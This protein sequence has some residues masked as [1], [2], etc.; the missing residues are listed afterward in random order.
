M[1]RDEAI[2]KIATITGH[3][4]VTIQ[5][6]YPGSTENVPVPAESNILIN[7]EQMGVCGGS[8]FVQVSKNKLI[9]KVR[10][11]PA[12]KIAPARFSVQGDVINIA[13][14]SSHWWEVKARGPMCIGVRLLQ[15]SADP[16]TTPTAPRDL[17]AEISAEHFAENHAAVYA[18][19][20]NAWLVDP[21]DGAVKRRLCCG[22]ACL[23]PVVELFAQGTVAKFVQRDP[24]V[25]EYRMFAMRRVSFDNGETTMVPERALHPNGP[26]NTPTTVSPAIWGGDT[27]RTWR[28]TIT[29]DAACHHVVKMQHH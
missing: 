8:E 4:L 5:L 7:E 2:A 13:G 17:T 14:R 3:R 1:S 25:V 20:G 12:I 11:F 18:R 26:I 22:V 19:D 10:R 21:S 6:L 9:M 24:K 27:N 15:Q 23:Q 16:D 28:A 29:S